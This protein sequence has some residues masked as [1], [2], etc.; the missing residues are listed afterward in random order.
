MFSKQLE[1]SE[2]ENVSERGQD[3]MERMVSAASGCRR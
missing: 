3:Y 2:S 1:E